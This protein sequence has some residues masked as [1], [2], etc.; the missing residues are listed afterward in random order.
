MLSHNITYLYLNTLNVTHNDNHFNNSK[1][2][3]A[4]QNFM[5]IIFCVSSY[6][7]FFNSVIMTL[8]EW[9]K[10]QEQKNE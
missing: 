5:S 1:K 6:L 3:H 4:K 2:K 8:S 7:L 10:N 9:Q